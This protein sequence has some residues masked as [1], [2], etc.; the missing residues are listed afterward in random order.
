MEKDGVKAIY[1]FIPVIVTY[2]IRVG[3]KNGTCRIDRQC[4]FGT[5]IVRFSNK[6]KR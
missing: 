5:V 2:N 1:W 4:T 6:G 3:E